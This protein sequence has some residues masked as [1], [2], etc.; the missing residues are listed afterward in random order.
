MSESVKNNRALTIA[1][2]VLWAAVALRIFLYN[3][4]NWDLSPRNLN[5]W[6]QSLT[7]GGIFFIFALICYYRG[8]IN[9]IAIGREEV[10]RRWGNGG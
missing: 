4:L 3:Y 9:G 5:D 6:L 2:L 8:R 7:T 10:N 1:C